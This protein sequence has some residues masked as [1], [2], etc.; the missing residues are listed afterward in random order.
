[1]KGLFQNYSSGLKIIVFFGVLLLALTLVLFISGLA[2]MSG[3]ADNIT[4]QKILQLVQSIGLYAIPPLVFAYLVSENPLEFLKINKTGSAKSYFW[5]VPV[6]LAAIPLINLLGFFNQQVVFPEFLSELEKQFIAYEEQLADL[7]EKFLAASSV[8]GLIFNLFLMAVVPAV[9]E[10]LLF[11]GAV[12]QLIGGQRHQIL[13]I[14]LTAFI[15]SAIHFQFYGFLPRFLLGA[16]L[17]YLFYWSKS[18]WLPI[19]AH[20]TNNAAVVIF[21]FLYNNK[22]ITLNPDEIGINDMWYLGVASAV[23]V[24]VFVFGL[25]K[26]QDTVR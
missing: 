26:N 6:M 7:T 5:V 11:R 9:S 2:L 20:F 1:M 25:R 22:K 16:F 17:G 18:L 14:W 23:V 12:Q 15:F 21:Y 8:S 10:E 3:N 19:L 24:T 4:M 13:A